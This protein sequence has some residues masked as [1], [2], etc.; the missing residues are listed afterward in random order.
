MSI[1]S[2]DGSECVGP[3]CAEMRPVN[4]T[5]TVP[6]VAAPMKARLDKGLTIESTVKVGA[7]VTRIRVVEMDFVQSSP[8]A[9][10]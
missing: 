6:L 5:P 4:A 9:D 3:A 10:H 2:V 8:H 7:A 1:V